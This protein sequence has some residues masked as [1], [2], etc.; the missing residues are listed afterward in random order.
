MENGE[1]PAEE[2]DAAEEGEAVEEISEEEFQAILAAKKRKKKHGIITSI[3]LGNYGY[4]NIL[5]H[6][7]QE[8]FAVAAVIYNPELA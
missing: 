4:Q 7:F 2:V 6:T 3:N 1:Y 5:Y 8:V